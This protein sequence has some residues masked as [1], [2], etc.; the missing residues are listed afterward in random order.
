MFW[1]VTYIFE[2]LL[3][4]RESDIMSHTACVC[5]IYVLFVACRELL[6]LF[7]FASVPKNWRKQ[8]KGKNPAMLVVDINILP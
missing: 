8:E 5:E 1:G 4:Q 2:E 7:A 6:R 3:H